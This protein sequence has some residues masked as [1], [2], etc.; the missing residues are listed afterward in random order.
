MTPPA[1]VPGWVR[2][3]AVTISCGKE[4]CI[5]GEFARSMLFYDVVIIDTYVIPLN[6]LANLLSGIA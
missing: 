2:C 1:P 5:C 4:C 6:N 3:G